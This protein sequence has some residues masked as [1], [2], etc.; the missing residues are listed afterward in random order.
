MSVR[1]L[2]TIEIQEE[3]YWAT[4]SSSLSLI[5]VLLHLIMHFDNWDGLVVIV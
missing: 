5:A 4:S 2:T 3:I 1:D